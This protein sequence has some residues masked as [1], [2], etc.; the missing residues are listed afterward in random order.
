MIEVMRA[1]WRDADFWLLLLFDVLLVYS[2]V[3]TLFYALYVLALALTPSR[4]GARPRPFVIPALF[5]L[6]A[7][8][9]FTPAKDVLT[10]YCGGV[11]NELSYHI[12]SKYGFAYTSH[13]LMLFWLA[14]AL[15]G[16]GMLCLRLLALSRFVKRLPDARRDR[17]FHD[18]CRRSGQSGVRLKI[19]GDDF[20]LSSWSGAGKY[21]IAPAG[22]FK[23]FDAEER[24]C[25]YLHE[26]THLRKADPCK[27]LAV[28]ACKCIFWFHPVVRRALRRF[29]SHLEIAC[30]SAVLEEYGVPPERYALL[31]GKM[32]PA[33]H[34]PVPGLSGSFRE[35]RW[36][37]GHIFRDPSLMP[38]GRRGGL[39]A[40]VFLTATLLFVS[41]FQGFIGEDPFAGQ[42]PAYN[43]RWQGILGMYTYKW[44]SSET[45]RP[46]APP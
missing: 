33:A 7:G 36:R 20:P 4:R 38:S 17:A 29:S 34:P 14:G 24:R 44:Y 1:A 6:S 19:A 37:L 15:A 39:L 46:N 45:P 26:L 25:A 9:A 22:F 12:M 5:L 18:A 23:A 8:T 30:D 28:A 41:F 16:G 40:A 11:F 42:R 21:V 2:L 43:F 27:L 10:S 31:L 35:I 13:L 3:F 32:L